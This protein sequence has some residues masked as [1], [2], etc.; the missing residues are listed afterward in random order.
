MAFPTTPTDG[1]F[2]APYQYESNIGAWVKTGPGIL[3]R[4]IEATEDPESI[5][6]SIRSEGGALVIYTCPTGKVAYVTS[7]KFCFQGTTTGVYLRWYLS[8]GTLKETIWYN[9]SYNTTGLDGDIR[10]S[11]P[12]KLN[13][14]DYIYLS[15]RFASIN[16]KLWEVDV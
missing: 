2:E 7:I 11:T 6:V 15:G 3:E 16:M 4:P 5:S 9:R 12:L 1:Q 14:G 8:G 10:F 13:V